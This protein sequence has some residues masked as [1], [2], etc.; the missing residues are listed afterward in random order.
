M[1][2]SWI[3]ESGRDSYSTTSKAYKIYDLNFNKV[4]VAR[5]VK[6]VEN[7]TWDWKNSSGE[8][9]KQLQ[10]DGLDA[11]K[12][13]DQQTDTAENIEQQTEW[14]AAENI[15]DQP[16]KGTRSLTDIYNKCNVAEAEPIHV[17]EAMNSQV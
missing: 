11:A 1:C 4:V 6:V 17:E 14:D 16:V 10:H 13:I 2:R 7:A 5:D 15:D 12:M 3:R 8:G 9:S